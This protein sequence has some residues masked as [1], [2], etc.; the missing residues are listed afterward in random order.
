M[1]CFYLATNLVLLLVQCQAFMWCIAI[2]FKDT[3]DVYFKLYCLDIDMPT[4]TYCCVSA[5]IVWKKCI[6]KTHIS[7]VWV[8]RRP[9]S[10]LR[11]WHKMLG[12]NRAE[13]H[14]KGISWRKI[15]CYITHLISKFPNFKKSAY[16]HQNHCILYE[17]PVKRKTTHHTVAAIQELL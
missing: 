8:H 2:G 10:P 4:F 5:V 12:E 16:R 15:S 14:T 6:P 9:W 13:N 7:D 1:L 3:K 11:R 17:P